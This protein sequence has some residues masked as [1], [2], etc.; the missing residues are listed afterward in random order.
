[1]DLHMAGHGSGVV[2]ARTTG[3]D[4]GAAARLDR[5]QAIGSGVPLW[6]GCAQIPS[7]R[8]ETIAPPPEG[9]APA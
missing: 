7:V 4:G 5:Q 1:M 3:H 8:D 9:A 2:T 6:Q